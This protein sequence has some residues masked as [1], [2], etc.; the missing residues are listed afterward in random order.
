MKNILNSAASI[1]QYTYCICAPGYLSPLS[2]RLT[3]LLINFDVISCSRWI[4]KEHFFTGRS[5]NLQ[6]VFY[7]KRH[8]SNTLK[9][10]RS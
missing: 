2:A 8:Y 7:D 10:S 5:C 6:V 9:S 4:I 1:I 3:P